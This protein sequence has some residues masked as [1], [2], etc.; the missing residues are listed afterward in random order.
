[1]GKGV[2]DENHP[3]CL[4]AAALSKDDFVHCAIDRADL[5]IN[6]GHDVIEKPPFLCQIKKVLLKLCTLTSSH[7][8]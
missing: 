6:V 3:M 8:K 7:L 2:V 1:M 5:I 4:S